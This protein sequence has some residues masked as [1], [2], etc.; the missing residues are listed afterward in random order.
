M[1]PRSLPA[2]ANSLA[3]ARI[4]KQRAVSFR[5][6]KCKVDEMNTLCTTEGRPLPT[7]CSK[8]RNGYALRAVEAVCEGR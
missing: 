1:Q 5:F 3:Q 8:S 2:R 6:T 4:G 7:Q